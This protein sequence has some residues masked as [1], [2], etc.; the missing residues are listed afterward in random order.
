[1]DSTPAVRPE[2][3]A[4]E[5]GMQYAETTIGVP[6]L[7]EFVDQGRITRIH[8]Q[9]TSGKEGTVY[10]CRAHP[11]TR[12]KFVAAKVY[13]QHTGSSY[14]WNATYFEG[15]ERVLKPQTLRAVQAHTAFG[16]AVAGGLWIEAEYDALQRLAAAGASTPVPIAL[17][18]HAILMEYIGNGAGPAPHLHGVDLDRDAARRAFAQIMEDITLMLR[19]HLV[20]GDLSP[21]N[22][23]FWKGSPRIIDLPQAVDARFNHAAPELFRRDVENVCRF[24]DRHGL[25]EDPIQWGIDLWDRYQRAAL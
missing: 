12:R 1:L 6:E 22:I 7:D 3:G 19:H 2:L 20:H 8:A 16:R 18:E 24:F 23:L 17:G 14:K 9:L 5:A 25:D 21:Y 13:R 4:L 11:S 10:C 15:R